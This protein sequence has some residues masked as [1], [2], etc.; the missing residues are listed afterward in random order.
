LIVHF[1]FYISPTGVK[2]LLSLLTYQ[3][4]ANGNRAAMTVGNGLVDVLPE[5]MSMSLN[6]SALTENLEGATINSHISVNGDNNA[7]VK[8]AISSGALPPGLLL[9]QDTGVISGTI[10]F[11]AVTAEEAV[12]NFNFTVEVIN[13]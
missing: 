10:P 3:Y 1:D 13:T 4:D 5:S 12:K 9:N 7:G 2:R 8:F 6:W 11:N